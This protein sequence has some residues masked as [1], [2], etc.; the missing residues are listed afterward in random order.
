MQLLADGLAHPVQPVPAAWA[1]LL[2]F[3]QVMLDALARQ[4]VRQRL[5]APLL[6]RRLLHVRHPRVRYGSRL[7]IIGFLSFGG[8]LLGFVEDALLAL[9]AARRVAVQALQTQLFLKMGDALRQRL[10]L[11]LQRGD[12]GC[13]R[14]EQ[15]GQRLCCG[16]AIHRILESKPFHLVQNNLYRLRGILQRQP[17]LRYR[18]A[19]WGRMAAMSMPSSS[20]CICSVDSCTTACCWPRG[21]AKRSASSRFIISQNPERS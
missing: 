14:R 21:Q 20:Q 18:R 16:G 7:G 12:L 13:V 4:T 19:G 3:G 15:G 5:A 10:V 6:R 17:T 9:L 1:G 8:R 2:I 11:G